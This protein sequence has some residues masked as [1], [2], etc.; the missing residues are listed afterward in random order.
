MMRHPRLVVLSFISTI[1]FSS[2]IVGQPIETKIPNPDVGY[3]A[4]HLG[5]SVSLDGDTLVVGA[6][7]T[8]LGGDLFEAGAAYVY[9]NQGAENWTLEAKLTASDAATGDAFGRAVAV[10]GDTLII[11]ATGADHVSQNGGAAYVFTRVGAEWT[12]RARLPATGRGNNALFG[13][14]IDYNGT[15]A[16]VGGEGFDGLGRAWLFSGSG[17]LWAQSNVYDDPLGQFNSRFGTDVILDGDRVL[18]GAPRSQQSDLISGAVFMFGISNPALIVTIAPTDPSEG[19]RFGSS[20]SMHRGTVLVGAPEDGASG[21]QAGAAYAF[22]E[23]GEWSQQAKL[24]PDETASFDFI[25]YDVIIDNNTAY[26]TAPNSIAIPDARGV[27][28]EFHRV[29]ADWTEVGTLSIPNLAELNNFGA[30]IA[31]N[32]SRFA[33]GTVKIDDIDDPGRVVLYA[34]SGATMTPIETFTEPAG[35]IFDF[36]GTAVAADGTLAAIGAMGDTTRGEFAGCVMAYELSDAVWSSPQRVLAQETDW[37]DRFGAALDLDGSTMIVGAPDRFKTNFGN[38]AAYIFERTGGIWL[39]RAQ[40]ALDAPGVNDFFGQSVAVSGSLAVVGVPQSDLFG[41]DAGLARVYRRDG[42]GVWQTGE[43]IAPP[44]VDTFSR[45]GFS[46]A[47]SGPNVIIGTYDA[48]V[49]YWFQEQGGQLI[50]KGPI[51]SPEAGGPERFGYSVD[52][53]GDAIVI[54]APE[55]S[56]SVDRSGT[57]FVFQRDGEVWNQTARL[58]APAQT[59]VGWFGQR[60]GLDGSYLVVGEPSVNRGYIFRRGG[61][62]GWFCEH[63]LAPSDVTTGDLFGGAVTVTGNQVIVGAAEKWDPEVRSGS[64]YGYDL[65]LPNPTSSGTIFY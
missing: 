38:G 12:Q 33:V 41:A 17:E 62:T 40:F 29:G 20:I 7:N 52:I 60:V 25:G 50:S 22:T 8:T 13:G 27:V 10:S 45:F 63:T 9:R 14:S 65:T 32:D 43:A 61:P 36:F 37:G 2:L 24:V 49:A 21:T 64:A 15:V 31:L 57:V 23:E 56:E 5:E 30:S 18:I 19:K 28:V 59:S 16:I 53:D 48:G 34:D 1:C 46:V 26:V 4:A 44:V 51:T 58:S 54:G 42:S 39:E 55:D 6:P 47:A 35:A 11:G 3:P